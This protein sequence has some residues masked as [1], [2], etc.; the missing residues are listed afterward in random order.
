MK[1]SC[2]VIF[3]FF[4]MRMSIAAFSGI[5]RSTIW[6]WTRH[7]IEDKPVARKA[8]LSKTARS[9]YNVKCTR[10]GDGLLQPD[11]TLG[12]DAVSASL[13]RVAGDR[14]AWLAG[15][16]ARARSGEGC[17]MSDWSPAAAAT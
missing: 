10:N 5:S 1:Q 14:A 3:R 16:A 11:R 13:C 2:A 6:R 17:G 7:G 12:A 15:P 9:H 8:Q 4:K